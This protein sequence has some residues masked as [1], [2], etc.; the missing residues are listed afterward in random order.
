[1]KDTEKKVKN[2][3]KWEDLNNIQMFCGQNNFSFA[4]KKFNTSNRIG[5]MF[6]NILSNDSTGDTAF[7]PD[8]YKHYYY[9]FRNNN[10]LAYDSMPEE[11]YI[12]KLY[13]YAMLGNKEAEES[14]ELNYE[15]AI[16]KA[17]ETKVYNNLLLDMLKIKIINRG[18]NVGAV[19]NEKMEE[20]RKNILNNKAEFEKYCS[21]EDLKILNFFYETKTF[22][23]GSGTIIY[24]YMNY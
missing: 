20:K 2:R 6:S 4:F 13:H 10:L 23:N 22:D 9:E 18:K 7:E 8:F 12:K 17:N 19:S 14:C 1:M 5:E 11:F 24:F 3:T 21:Q 16:A 15:T